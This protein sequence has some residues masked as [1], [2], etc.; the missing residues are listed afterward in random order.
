[1]FYFLIL[2]HEYPVRNWFWGV[3]LV[4]AM[5]SCQIVGPDGPE[6]GK[7][8]PD[9]LDLPLIEFDQL[10]NHEEGEFEYNIS[11][12][13]VGI[14]YCPPPK[15]CFLPDGISIYPRALPEN[16]LESILFIT[17]SNPCQFSKGEEYLFSISVRVWPNQEGNF[18]RHYGIL[19]YR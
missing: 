6:F 17:A 19:G 15:M 9:A 16:H 13:V 3:V 5:C 12:Y 10:I 18:R 14:S 2:K 1:M 4:F 11:A 8:Y 7:S